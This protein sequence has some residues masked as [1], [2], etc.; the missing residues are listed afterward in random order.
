M[1]P[2]RQPLLEADDQFGRMFAPIDRNDVG[3]RVRRGDL[4][5]IVRDDGRHGYDEVSAEIPAGIARYGIGHLAHQI[6]D[7]LIAGVGLLHPHQQHREHAPRRRK[8]NDSLARAGNAD[9]SGI[10]VGPGVAVGHQIGRTHAGALLRGNLEVVRRPFDERA[11][12]GLFQ[13]VKRPAAIRA[14]RR[15]AADR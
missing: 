15:S 2:R 3:L 8:I 14:A 9:D 11:D 1:G 6:L 13:H 4:L 10:V 7:V 12:L 5:D